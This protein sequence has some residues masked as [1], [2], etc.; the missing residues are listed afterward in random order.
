MDLIAYVTTA[1]GKEEPGFYFVPGGV[2][3]GPAGDLMLVSEK[4]PSGA[5]IEGTIYAPGT[6]KSI[7]FNPVEQQ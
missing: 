2:S 6:W 4:G 7:S 5:P 1:D 3:V